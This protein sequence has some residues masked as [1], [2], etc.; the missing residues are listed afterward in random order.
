MR[1]FDRQKTYKRWSD[2][3]FIKPPKQ[4]N[5]SKVAFNF[6]WQFLTWAVGLSLIIT[7]LY[8]GITTLYGKDGWSIVLKLFRV[9]WIPYTAY[10]FYWSYRIMR[11]IIYDKKAYKKYLDY[12]NSQVKED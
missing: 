1:E 2:K 9:T 5:Y 12:I 11:V 3:G 10:C 7:F 8:G 4:I 6:V